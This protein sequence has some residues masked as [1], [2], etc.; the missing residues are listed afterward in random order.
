MSGFR[1][2][3]TILTFD[4]GESLE[5]EISVPTKAYTMDQLERTIINKINT[6]TPPHTCSKVTRVKIFRNYIEGSL[7]NK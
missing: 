4:S 1:T 7:L 6:N 2:Y 3:P 5:A